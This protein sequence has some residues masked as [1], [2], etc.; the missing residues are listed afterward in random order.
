MTGRRATGAERAGASRLPPFLRHPPGCNIPRM[1]FRTFRSIATEA[2]EALPPE[3][4]AGIDGLEV[5]RDTVAHPSLPEVYTLGE[6]L[7]EEYPSEYGGVG[8]VRSVVV[9]YHGSFR[10]LSRLEAGFDWEAEIWET[11][12]HEV[13]H[14]LESRAADDALEETDYAEYQNFALR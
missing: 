4:R 8:E 11:V 13:R 2:Y 6:C 9:L 7:T 12:T 14:H 1:D 3:F 5:S 10:A